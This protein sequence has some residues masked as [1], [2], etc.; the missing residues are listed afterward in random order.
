M[1]WLIVLVAVGL[2]LLTAGRQV[3]AADKPVIDPEAEKHLKNMGAY[4]AKLKA[5]SFQADE[6]SDE[7]L[8]DLQKLQLANRRQVTVQRPNHVRSDASGDT[9]NRDFYYDGATI[10]MYDKAK[11]VY[12]SAKV[13][14]TI[15]AMLDE[16]HQKFGQVPPLADFLFADPYKV[17][18]AHVQSGTYAGL[19]HVEGVK[20]HHLA[21]RQKQL[22]WQIWIEA[23]EQPLP[24]K[25][26]MTYKREAGG[27]QFTAIL[28]QW[29][30]NPKV[31]ESLFQFEPPAGVR[32]IEILKLAETPK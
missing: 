9:L 5:F 10:T 7:V 20:C 25:L 29:D 19:H 28:R 22:D 2:S 21:F 6:V 1:Q 15:D 23:G 8:D 31:S 12:A 26:V 17:L 4:L 3:P 13:A 27:P 24:R 14:G 18:T 32:K 16:A 11:K 30:V